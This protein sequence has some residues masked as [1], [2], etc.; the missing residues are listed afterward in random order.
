MPDEVTAA[1]ADDWGSEGD[2]F[3]DFNDAAE[4]VEDDDFG[5]FNE[6]DAQQ[7]AAT[8]PAAV[9]ASTI[10]VPGQQGQQQQDPQPAA[11]TVLTN[12]STMA[13]MCSCCAYLESSPVAVHSVR[14]HC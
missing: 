2:D 5:A 1:T 3:G 8:P 9:P 12:S 11:G 7:A 6:A 13:I 4:G 10:A 14:E